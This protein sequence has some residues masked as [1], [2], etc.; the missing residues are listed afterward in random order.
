MLLSAPQLI[1]R[2][3]PSLAMEEGGLA[4]PTTLTTRG[5][6]SLHISP[7]RATLRGW[8]NQLNKSG[9][10]PPN[11]GFPFFLFS[12]NLVGSGSPKWEVYSSPVFPSSPRP[13]SCCP[14]LPGQNSHTLLMEAGGRWQ[15]WGKGNVGGRWQDMSQLPCPHL[16]T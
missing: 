10:F 4:V 12:T 13:P 7:H 15:W 6:P 1:M 16:Q 2:T 11:L 14:T 3:C 9:C 8:D 5:Q